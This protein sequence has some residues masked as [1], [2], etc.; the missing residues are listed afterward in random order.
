MKELLQDVFRKLV[1]EIFATSNVGDR[2]DLLQ[3]NFPCP[4][5]RVEREWFASQKRFGFFEPQHRWTDGT[6]SNAGVLDRVTVQVHPNR[7]GEG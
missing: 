2:R 3:R 7:T 5:H 6:V 1:P 4:A